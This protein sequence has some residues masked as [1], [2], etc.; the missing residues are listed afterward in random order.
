MKVSYK[1]EKLFH[2]ARGNKKLSKIQLIWSLPRVI[3]CPGAGSCKAWCY[4]KKSESCYKAV[5]PSR[6]RNWEFSKCEEFVETIVSFL[7]KTE[8]KIVRVHEAGDFYSQLYLDKW[9]EIARKLPNITFYAF[10]KSFQLDLW[11]KLP[12]NLI[13]LQSYGSRYDNLIDTT[14]NTA[15]VIEKIIEIH[16]IEYLCPYH[17]EL[18]TKCGECCSYCYNSKNKTKHIAFLKH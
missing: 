16:K 8:K 2:F 3:T 12:E 10:T 14:K 17:D 11:S 4:A 18:F 15:R 9:K 1:K 7:K 5:L 6:M 13:I